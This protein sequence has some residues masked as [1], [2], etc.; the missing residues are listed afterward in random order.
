[1][2][3]QTSRKKEQGREQGRDGK[4]GGRR[5]GEK[6]KGR[7]GGGGRGTEA[8]GQKNTNKIV[9]WAPKPYSNYQGPYV[10]AAV[11]VFGEAAYRL[12][13]LGSAGS[14]SKSTD[15]RSA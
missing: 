7:G 8:G 2:G 9:S 1:M 13:G 10:N 3:G 14:I 4:V 6:R 5:E 11:F 15:K 12:G